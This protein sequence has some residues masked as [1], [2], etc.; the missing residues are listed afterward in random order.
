M[1]T[2]IPMAFVGSPEMVTAIAI[3]GRLDFNPIT[4]TLINEDGQEVKLDEPRGYELPPKGF[5]V[6]DAGYLAPNR[7][8]VR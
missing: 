3:S 4:D 8:E 2:Q 6:E 7:M 5:E 1:E